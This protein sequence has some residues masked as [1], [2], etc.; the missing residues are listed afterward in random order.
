[1]ES[2]HVSPAIKKNLSDQMRVLNP[3]HLREI[4]EANLERIFNT[5][6]RKSL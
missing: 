4:I 2:L 6:M 1:M 3:F 5:Q